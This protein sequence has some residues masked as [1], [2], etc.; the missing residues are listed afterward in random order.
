MHRRELITLIGGAAAAWPLPARA[1]HPAMPV[2][3]VLRSSSAS[4]T[5]HLIAAF[6]RGLKE[7]GLIE[8]QNVAIEYRWA[9]GRLEQLPALVTDLIRRPVAVI[10][11]NQAAAQAAKQAT[12]TVPIVFTTGADPIRAGLVESLSR[13][14]GNVTGIVFP[15]GDLTAKRLGLL[16]ELVPNALVIA[17]L[18]DPNSPAS[19]E[20]LSGLEQARRSIGRRIE[21]VKIS[22]EREIQTAFETIAQARAGALLVGGGP[23]FLSQHR[24]LVTIAARHALPASYVTRSYIEAGGL[25]SYGPSM[26]EAYRKAGAYAARILKGAKPSDL[27]VEQAT[28]FDLIINLKTA[29]ALGLT[30]PPN[31]LALADEVIE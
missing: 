23:F 25:M 14:G 10:V 4:G 5:A 16:H 9:D 15:V 7:G 30:V 8:G 24:Q 17:V 28:K 12:A 3:G 27:P 22:S 29:K 21:V 26:T 31:L 19:D 13:P 2:V 1:Q 6:Q 20:A 11:A 18:L